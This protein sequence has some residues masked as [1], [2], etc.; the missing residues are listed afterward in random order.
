MALKIKLKEEKRAEGNLL[1]QGYECYFPNLYS[2]L[3]LK[4]KSEIKKHPMFPGYAFVKSYPSL[5]LKPVEFTRGVIGV[6]R[7]GNDYPV[8]SD[9]VIKSIRNVEQESIKDPKKASYKIGEFIIV[10]SG[11]LKDMPALITKNISDQ[12]VEIL[13]SLLNRTHTIE[14]NPENISKNKP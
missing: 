1:N 5:E 14:L 7:F 9:A 8:L 3:L 4:N 13:Y 10:S 6:V 11:P 12:R 2:N